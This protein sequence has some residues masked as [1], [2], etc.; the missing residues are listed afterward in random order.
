MP[1]NSQKQ[2]NLLFSLS[3]HAKTLQGISSLLE[4]D[5]ETYMPEGSA[6][7]R[8]EQVKTLA[9]LVHQCKTAKEYEGALGSLI[10]IKT[11]ALK[12]K[13]L[14][15]PKQRA[16]IM[17]RRDFVKA[18]ALPTSF[19]EEFAA[20]TSKSVSVWRAA[21]EKSSFKEFAP[22]LKKIID[23]CRKKAELIGYE[24]HPYDALIDEFEPGETAD[25]LAEL[26]GNVK[27]SLVS[28]IAKTQTKKKIDDSFLRG[29]F[30]PEK[31]MELGNEILKDIG[32]D[33]RYGRVDF[34]THPFSSS[35]H[36]Q[37]SR[38][39]TRKPSDNLIAN[40][41]IL[42]HEGG[43]S[44]YEMGLPEKEYG[45][46]LAEAVSLGIHESQSRFY[47]IWI[48]QGKPFWKR[49]F[50]KLADTFGGKLKKVSFDNFYKAINKVAPSF[51]RVDADELTYPMHVI[52]RFEIEKALIEG[53]ASVNEIPDLWRSKMKEMLGIVPKTDQ[54]GCLQDI[55]W[56]MGAFGYFPTYLLGSMYA[57]Q[58]FDAFQA[59]NPDFEERIQKEGLS[60]IK[61]YLGKT[62]HRHGRQYD[63]REL[64]KRATGKAFSPAAYLNYLQKKY[65]A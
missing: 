12:A 11:G 8:A 54:E 53:S 44:L 49:Y 7:I 6:S 56:S 63:S 58:I 37:D 40:I 17:W 13:D 55:H 57:A 51:I 26:F 50:P 19:V 21:K 20:L 62:I 4:W 47:E 38:I 22:Y 34:S 46:P 41:S 64:I 1:K 45:S 24:K 52:L 30:D 2:Y 16:L 48:G 15:L 33:F 18:K 43:H 39:T 36:P 3:K 25:N 23:L 27:P 28:L 42:M 59:K 65:G 10:N 14:P 35:S 32:F 61:D 60:F 29:N 5:H 9:G 31:Q